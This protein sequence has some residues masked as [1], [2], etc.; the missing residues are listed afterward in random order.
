MSDFN[1][2]EIRAYCL[3]KKGV[4]ES[5]PFDNDTLVLKVLNKMFI[6]IS[7]EQQPLSFNVKCDPE[8]AVQL[9]ETYP[10]NVLPGYHMNKQ[11]WNTVIVSQI[12]SIS[13]L[14][15]FIDDSYQLVLNSIPKSKQ[16]FG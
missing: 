7:L 3:N 5:F 12:L 10:K 14:K 11:H 2:E 13:L 4:T 9:R 1:V 8:R 6:L 15:S 16:L